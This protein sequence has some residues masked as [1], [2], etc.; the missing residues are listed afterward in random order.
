M[1]LVA[2]RT[3]A[4]CSI[5]SACAAPPT[6]RRRHRRARRSRA[7]L[8]VDDT[9]QSRS[10]PSQYPQDSFLTLGGP[11]RGHG[12]DAPGPPP[13]RDG[14]PARRLPDPA[15]RPPGHA[16]ST[17][18]APGSAS[19]GS[20]R[21]ATASST[22]AR[23]GRGSGA[24]ASPATA[25]A[26]RSG[27]SA[28]RARD[29]TVA[30]VREL[31][32]A[33]AGSTRSCDPRLPTQC[34]RVRRRDDQPRVGIDLGA[35]RD[36]RR[37]ARAA[38]GG[39]AAVAAAGTFDATD[40]DAVVATRGR[41]RTRSRSTRPAE[42]STAPHRDDE[43]ISRKFRIARCGEI[44]LGEQARIWVPW[45][46]P[47]DPDTVPGWMQVGLRGVGTRCAPRATSRSR[48]TRPGCSGSSPADVP[49]KQDDA[50]RAPTRGSTSSRRTSSSRSGSTMWSH[51]GID[52]LAAALTAHQKRRRAS[53]ARAG[54]TIPRATAPRS[55]SRRTAGLSA[56]RRA[57]G[58]ARPGG[59]GRLRDTGR[60]DMDVLSAVGLRTS[61]ATIWVV[62]VLVALVAG[63]LGAIADDR[64]PSDAGRRRRRRRRGSSPTRC[65][66]ST[67]AATSSSSPRRPRRPTPTR[68]AGASAA[69]CA[70]V[71]V[72]S[73]GSFTLWLAAPGR[74]PGFGSPCSSL[75]SCRQGRNVIINEARWL[76]ASPVVERGRRVAARLPAHGDEPRDRPLDRLRARGLRRAGRA[77][78]GDAAAVDLAAGLRAQLLAA[79]LGAPLGRGRASAWRSATAC[80]SAR[81]SRSSRG[82]ARCAS[83][84]WA[85]DPDT[86]APDIVQITVDGA[87]SF[88]GAPRPALTTSPPRYPGYGPAHGFDAID[89]GC[90][91]PALRV[92]VRDEH[93][94]RRQHRAPRLPHRR[95]RLAVRLGRA[96]RQRPAHRARLRLGHRP[97]H[98]R[99]RRRSTST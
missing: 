67:T 54:T 21:R 33:R 87:S 84:G 25:R 86:A 14:V 8:Y 11:G 17:T 58:P 68:A 51:D 83:S 99:R 73:G 55:G 18:A 3:T 10:T 66:A 93:R 74:V 72:P 71:R 89:P 13:L 59:A 36:P 19:S 69:R 23:R 60:E 1:P 15:P 91:R 27:W 46:T 31:E 39:A 22:A 12:L 97:R 44:A 2:A 82:C 88:I 20:A 52:A 48:S 16:G 56:L 76:G 53:P 65:A 41:R 92:R 38:T 7:S 6:S 26:P 37:R 5:R 34:G 47:P 96:R 79:R 43:A 32:R 78:A 63:S 81:S 45:V 49:P 42:L 77:R 9:E 61:I 28:T 75:Y 40:L 50:G 64:E 85:I 57:A 35:S 24:S 29:T 80:R 98:A 4:T 30:R 90:E 62:A 95:R 70:F 94:R